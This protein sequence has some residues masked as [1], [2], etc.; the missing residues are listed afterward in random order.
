VFIF[1]EEFQEGRHADIQNSSVV[2]Q[3]V[4][5]RKS[6]GKAVTHLSGLEPG[7]YLSL[8]SSISWAGMGEFSI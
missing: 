8:V 2:P 1:K 6:L 3:Q 4:F 7:F 5:I